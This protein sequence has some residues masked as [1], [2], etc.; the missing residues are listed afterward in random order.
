M[1]TYLVYKN[2]NLINSKVYIGITSHISN[3]NERWRNG[4]GYKD[5]QFYMAILKYGWDNFS[6]EILETNISEEEIDEKECYYIALYNSNNPEYGYNLTAGGQKIK[7]IDERSR[8]KIREKFTKERREEY[9]LRLKK[10]WKEDEEFIKKATEARKSSTWHPIG[11]L[12]PMY[13]THRTGKDAGNK[14]KVLCIETGEVF[15]TVTEA[16]KWSNNGKTSTRS[17]IA[18]VCQGKRNTCGKHPDSGIPLHWKYLDENE[19]DY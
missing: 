5:Q 19:V 3:P 10:R 4:E 2:T 17:H 18:Q 6:H 13:G 11:E 15:E 7:T 9:S 16:A 12:N 8:Q 1:R 14:R